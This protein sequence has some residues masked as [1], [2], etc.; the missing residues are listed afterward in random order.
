MNRGEETNLM[1]RSL[2]NTYPTCEVW[3]SFPSFKCELLPENAV[4]KEG[5]NEYFYS[6]NTWQTTLARWSTLTYPWYSMIKMIPQIHNPSL[7]TRKT[8][9][10]PQWR[11]TPQ[12]IWPGIIYKILRLSRLLIQG[13]S[14]K[15]LQPKKSKETEYS[16]QDGILKQKRDIK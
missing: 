13:K 3:H 9:N 1:Q 12:N 14:E 15:L 16:V 6:R 2:N 4:W 8:L 7:I 5:G 11:D 10:K